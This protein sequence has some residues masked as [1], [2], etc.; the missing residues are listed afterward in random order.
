MKPAI[1]VLGAGPAGLTFARLL[2]NKGIPC[3]VF[4]RD[5][6]PEIRTHGGC[7]DLHK[8]N[9]Q[10]ALKECGLFDKFRSLA[11]YDGQSFKAYDKQGTSLWDLPYTGEE[12][13]RPE[14]DRKDLRQLLLDSLAPGTIRWDAKV[15]SVQRDQDGSMAIELANGTVEKE[16]KLIV[17]ADGAWSKARKLLISSEPVYSGMT[18]L[19]ST[20]DPSNPSHAKIAERA[21][22]GTYMGLSDGKVL[23]AMRQSN[24]AYNIYAGLRLPEEFPKTSAELIKSPARMR[25]HFIAEKFDDWASDLTE[26]FRES[27]GEIYTW[28]MYM[29]PP[30]S[31]PWKHQQGVT[32]LGDAA[33]LSIT[34]GD[35]V[36]LAMEDALDL[37][38]EIESNGESNLD[39]AV[40]K[41]EEKMMPRGIKHMTETTQEVMQTLFAEDSP[42]GF[43]EWVASMGQA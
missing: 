32:L 36:N 18:F 7:L 29:L 22:T 31:L 24:G 19:Q 10:Q 28:P 26:L 43:K 37:A 35:G 17:G 3:V 13:A 12:D 21:G 9:G 1:A 16:F 38:H 11:R 8:H 5:P 14:I 40:R 30:E 41:Y 15:K 4:E 25:E 20:V 42:R 6:T 39:E 27:D 33:H 2:A 23:M 34:T